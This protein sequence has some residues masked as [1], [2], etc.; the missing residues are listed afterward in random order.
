MTSSGLLR[1]CTTCWGAMRH[2]LLPN[3][4]KVIYRLGWSRLIHMLYCKL[5]EEVGTCASFHILS[6]GYS[7]DSGSL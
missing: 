3:P 7:V 5:S 1:K 6:C 2:A 4:T